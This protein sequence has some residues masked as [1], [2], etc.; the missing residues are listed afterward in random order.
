MKFKA[1][2]SFLLLVLFLGASLE[3]DAQRRNRYK[4]RKRANKSISR[5]RGGSVGG[6][7]VPYQFASFNVNALNYFG[8]L[9]PVNRAAS[10]DVNFTRPGFGG[11]VGYKFSPYLAVRAGFNYGRLKGDDITSDP[12]EEQSAPRYQRNLSFRNDIKELHLGFELYLIPNYGGPNRRPPINGYVFVGAALFHHEPQ[13]LVPDYDHTRGG[14]NSDIVA[15]QAGEWVKLRPLGTE[16]QFIDGVDVKTYSPI[17]FSIPVA[18]G[19]TF[20]LPG[21]F[22][23]GVEFGYRFLFT[24]YIDDV[25]TNYVGF[26]KFEDPLAR[27][28]SDRSAEPMAYWAGISRESVVTTVSQTLDDGV[29]YYSAGGS[30]GIGGGIAEGAIR[31]NPKDRDMVFITSLKLT[32]I[33]TKRRA[34]FR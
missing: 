2:L 16:G 18:I 33:I 34:H 12:A 30:Y 13:G 21:P 8:D 31:G 9:A 22:T 32:Y 5:Y 27:I 7:F 15:P 1:V 28:M 11:N 24:D 10:T 26:D 3:A 25:S 6:R 17:Q 20:R 14:F 19:A 23:A 29:Q 4:K